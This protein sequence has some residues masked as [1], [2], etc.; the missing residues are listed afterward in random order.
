MGEKAEAQFDASAFELGDP[1]FVST[2]KRTFTQTV[3][4]LRLSDRVPLFL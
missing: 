1:Q 2:R 4:A 3:V